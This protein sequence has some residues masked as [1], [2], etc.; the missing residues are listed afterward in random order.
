MIA[1]QN[2]LYQFERSLNP[3]VTLQR[4]DSENENK[5]FIP[6][7]NDLSTTHVI[8]QEEIDIKVEPMDPASIFIDMESFSTTFIKNES[9]QN[10]PQQTEGRRFKTRRIKPIAQTKK[11]DNHAKLKKKRG[12]KPKSKEEL[13]QN[14]RIRIP[15][16]FCGKILPTD[17]M[18]RHVSVQRIV[19]ES[20]QS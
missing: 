14:R 17:Y 1:N 2:R 3:Q 7:N 13:K 5:S 11:V 6:L 20:T 19:I 15:C 18:K 12:R 4:F 16:T 10:E 8:K 9:H